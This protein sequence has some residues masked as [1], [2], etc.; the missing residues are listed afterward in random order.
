MANGRT[1]KQRSESTSERRNVGDTAALD[2]C[3]T[4]DMLEDCKRPRPEGGIWRC[5]AYADTY[6]QVFD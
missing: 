3:A 6:E 2:L 4:C 1:S 5:A